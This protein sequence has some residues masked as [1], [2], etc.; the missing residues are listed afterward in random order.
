MARA[1]SSNTGTVWPGWGIQNRRY[2]K[3]VTARPP[4]PSEARK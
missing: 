4:A 2:M 3:K 1:M